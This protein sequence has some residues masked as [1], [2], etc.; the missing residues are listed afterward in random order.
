MHKLIS[1]FSVVRA[2]LVDFFSERVFSLWQLGPNLDIEG[3]LVQG[4][5]IE[6]LNCLLRNPK[7]FKSF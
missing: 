6:F 1:H 3:F 5:L 2:S 4:V 7:S